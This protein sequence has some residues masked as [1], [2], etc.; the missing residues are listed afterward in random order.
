MCYADYVFVLNA[1]LKIN[2]V[3]NLRWIFV[4]LNQAN[5]VIYSIKLP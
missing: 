2:C 4:K 3:C 5:S 1:T